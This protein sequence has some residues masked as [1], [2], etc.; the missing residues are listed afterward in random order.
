MLTMDTSTSTDDEMVDFVLG[1]TEANGLPSSAAWARILESAS[2]IILHDL[3]YY[4]LREL[5]EDEGQTLDRLVA[6]DVIKVGSVKRLRL[7]HIEGFTTCFYVTE[8]GEWLIAETDIDGT[9]I[10]RY[11]WICTRD[12]AKTFGDSKYPKE[13]P[14][15]LLSSLYRMIEDRLQQAERRTETF[16][17]ARDAVK[18]IVDRARHLTESN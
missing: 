2:S 17:F 10:I 13:L 4:G 3:K 7:I 12:M 14:I 8:S 11:E 18:P 5:K 1:R 16:R 15:R 9:R 6:R